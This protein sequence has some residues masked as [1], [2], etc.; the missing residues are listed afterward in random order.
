LSCYEL[1][2][3]AMLPW[4]GLLT[5]AQVSAAPADSIP[6]AAVPTQYSSIVTV[7]AATEAA[8]Q[9]ALDR[10]TSSSTLLHV[11]LQPGSGATIKLVQGLT[12][13]KE[14]GP[15]LISALQ[16]DEASSSSGSSSDSRVLLDC[17]KVR[18]AASAVAVYSSAS[19]TLRNFAVT[20]CMKA[21]AVV[22]RAGPLTLF[23]MYFSKNKNTADGM[24]PYAHGTASCL[25]CQ[26]LTVIQ[27]NFESNYAVS[28]RGRNKRVLRASLPG[29]VSAKLGHW[30]QG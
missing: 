4:D 2:R 5:P 29:V 17:S 1:L 3:A 6:P 14:A 23:D 10:H 11:V 13:P 28:C 26:A 27:S 8:V 21:P 24:D 22:S 25:N 18:Q 19:V 12:V 15:V 7:N 20:G 16:P 30:V 9:E